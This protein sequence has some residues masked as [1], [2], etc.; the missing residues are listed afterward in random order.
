MFTASHLK[1][2]SKQ[3]WC[4]CADFT[5]TKYISSTVAGELLDQAIMSFTHF[6]VCVCERN[7][8]T[9]STGVEVMTFLCVCRVLS[10]QKGAIR[11]TCIHNIL[12]NS[13]SLLVTCAL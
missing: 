2:A 13:P 8:K 3:T 10:Q 5:V 1:R 9:S 7:I 12:P 4:L 11:L 6:Y